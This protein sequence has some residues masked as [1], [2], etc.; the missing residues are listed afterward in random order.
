M[1]GARKRD[2]HLGAAAQVGQ[3]PWFEAERVEPRLAPVSERRLG[4]EPDGRRH[5][6]WKREM[7]DERPS[8]AVG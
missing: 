3:A 6:R 4:K 2:D 1:V 5:A 8:G 7:A